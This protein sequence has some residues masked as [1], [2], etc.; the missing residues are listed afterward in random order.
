MASFDRKKKRN[1][2]IYQAEK[3]WQEDHSI[4]MPTVLIKL[5]QR[6]RVARLS[7][8]VGLE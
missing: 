3:T 6:L 7:L 1:F 4:E 2:I 5:R 8:K